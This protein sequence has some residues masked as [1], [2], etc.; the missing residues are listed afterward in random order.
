MLTASP[1]L[2]VLET[3]V[4][5]CGHRFHVLVASQDFV[6][7]VLVRTILPKNNPPTIVHDKV[8]N[9]IQVRA[10]WGGWGRR[11]VLLLPCSVP[12]LGH[13]DYPLIG[14]WEC[15]ETCQHWALLWSRVSG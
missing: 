9:L 10:G 14:C 8:L 1:G 7:G 2:Q 12:C 4:K 11:R 3:C 6:E 13:L 5:N 15:G